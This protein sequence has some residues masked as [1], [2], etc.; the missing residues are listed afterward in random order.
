MPQFI[1]DVLALG[2]ARVI[3]KTKRNCQYQYRAQLA[4]AEQLR[5]QIP[6][7]DYRTSYDRGQR[8]Q[9]AKRIVQQAGLGRVQLVFVKEFNRRRQLTQR[10]TLMCTDVRY[11]VEQVFRAHQWRWRIEEC[12]RELR[13]NHAL[14]QFH[15]RNL[16]AIVGHIVLSYLSYLC[17]ALTRWLTPKLK[18]KTLGWIKQHVFGALVTLEH[19]GDEIRIGFTAS[20]LQDI[21]LPDFCT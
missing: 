4:T 10:Y 2:F 19:V 5:E 11:P 16:N 7:R 18:H 1:R 21:G 17:L 8:A 13:Q 9:L 3:I 12:Y 6:Q 14:E 15:G 20:F